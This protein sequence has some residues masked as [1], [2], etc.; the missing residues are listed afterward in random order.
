MA[1]P[2]L[3][4]PFLLPLLLPRQPQYLCAE[5]L[6]YAVE[7][8]GAQGVREAVPF[9]LRFVLRCVLRPADVAFVDEPFAVLTSVAQ[10]PTRLPLDGTEKPQSRAFSVGEPFV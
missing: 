5:S 10:W 1:A 9:A 6:G 3:L 2:F 4:L 7:L 8:R